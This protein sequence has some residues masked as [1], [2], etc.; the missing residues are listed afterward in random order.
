MTKEK[1]TKA[2]TLTNKIKEAQKQLDSVN[3]RV[4][5]DE[6]YHITLGNSGIDMNT[7]IFSKEFA[8]FIVTEIETHLQAQIEEATEQFHNL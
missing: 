8:E 7:N 2:L 5:N 6:C 4:I 3:M 1:L